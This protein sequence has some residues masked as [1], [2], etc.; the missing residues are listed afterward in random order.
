MDKL[1]YCITIVVCPGF[2]ESDVI[3]CYL[4]FSGRNFA[5]GRLPTANFI[6]KADYILLKNYLKKQ[7]RLKR[8]GID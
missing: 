5:E 3:W 4:N 7:L 8:K 2:F 6:G 1:Q